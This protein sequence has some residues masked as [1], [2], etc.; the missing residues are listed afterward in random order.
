[1]AIKKL[2][3]FN[4]K[5]ELTKSNS[6]YD[7]IERNGLRFFIS[8][9]RNLDSNNTIND[10]SGNGYNATKTSTLT[11][12][13]EG[14]WD[15]GNTP[16]SDKYILIPKDTIVGS[17]TWTFE[18]WMNAYALNGRYWFHGGGTQNSCLIG[19]DTI[20]PDDTAGAKMS[21]YMGTFPGSA[22]S[23]FA[24][25]TPADGGAYTIPN[26]SMYTNTLHHIVFSL[27]PTQG[28]AWYIDG[29][30][31]A[32]SPTTL[33]T[34]QL[35]SEVYSTVATCFTANN[36]F[37]IGQELDADGASTPPNFYI[38][39]SNQSF[40]GRAYAIRLYNTALNAE[41]VLRNYRAGVFAK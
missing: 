36:S 21:C 39:D 10:L 37:W 25:A 32:N 33:S 13:S 40:L 17:N 41:Q 35:F 8:A 18:W 29:V 20:T 28:V 5:N 3:T 7:G 26:L 16:H 22:H 30:K 11:T 31:V 38:L 15:F 34:G 23:F 12:N 4:I 1:M 27:S 9:D 6:F 19:P 14:Y 2:S 24:G